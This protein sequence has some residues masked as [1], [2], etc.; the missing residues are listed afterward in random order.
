MEAERVTELGG[1]APLLAAGV[2]LIAERGMEA[3]TLEDLAARAGLE[4]DEV[5]ARWSDPA[6][7]IADCMRWDESRFL[8]EVHDR[9]GAGPPEVRLR[10]LVQACVTQF[11]WTLWIELWSLALREAWAAKLRAELDE[12]FRAELLG[13]IREGQETGAFGT[14]D[15]ERAAAIIASLLDGFATQAT[16]GD[17][18]IS[19]HFMHRACLWTVDR[20]LGSN[21]GRGVDG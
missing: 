11:D 13:L 19:A 8:V 14:V 1:D 9:T 12:A 18:Y 17:S 15:S 10:A 7:A 6:Q 4:V 21:L 16:L 20:L 3:F 5:L 2:H